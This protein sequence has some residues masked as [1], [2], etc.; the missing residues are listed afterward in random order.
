MIS[1]VCSIAACGVT[2]IW[3]SGQPYG[4]NRRTSFGSRL[5]AIRSARSSRSRGLARAPQ[6]GD[7][8]ARD[9]G[10]QRPH[11]A[12][13]ERVV[14]AALQP[15]AAVGLEHARRGD[16]DPGRRVEPH[17]PVRC[18]IRPRL[19]HAEEAVEPPGPA[20][21][22]PDRGDRV[23]QQRDLA[24]VAEPVREH[25]HADRDVERHAPARAGRERGGEPQR[26]R[27]AARGGLPRDRAGDVGDPHVAGAA[28]AER[29]VPP[30]PDPD[31]VE[32]GRARVGE[33]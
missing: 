11:P 20:L 28:A 31:Q 21:E 27:G 2:T 29:A 8:D 17:R 3:R 16:P 7:R 33:R 25:R 24:A 1:P 15:A 22:V 19:A 9:I 12:R 30:Q 10:A 6:H 4:P 23:R 26:D 5:R 13:G 18:G 14:A 32:R